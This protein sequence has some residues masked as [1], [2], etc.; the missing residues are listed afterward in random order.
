MHS[1]FD[2]RDAATRF[3]NL[4]LDQL[5]GRRLFMC[6]DRKDRDRILQQTFDCAAERE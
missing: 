1:C 4:L 6:P 3:G 5:F 2:W